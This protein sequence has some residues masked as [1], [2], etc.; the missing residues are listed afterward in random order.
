MDRDD[1][2]A[3][4]LVDRASGELS[5]SIS[6]EPP[7]QIPHDRYVDEAYG[8][9]ERVRTSCDL[10]QLARNERARDDDGEVFGPSPAEHQPGTFRQ[11]QRPVDEQRDTHRLKLLPVES[12]DRP[13]RPD[14]VTAIRVDVQ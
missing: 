4:A 7:R 11:K 3:L 5:A 9:S 2:G 14:E 1:I 13:N 6:V 8:G 12:C 10:V